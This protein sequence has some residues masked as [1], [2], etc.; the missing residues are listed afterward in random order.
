M[1]ERVPQLPF[2]VEPGHDVFA[3][4][5]VEQLGPVTA[6]LL[7]PVHGG[8]GVAKERLGGAAVGDGDP[9]AGGDDG[10]EPIEVERL[11]GNVQEPFSERVGL[12]DPVELLA[13]DD[14][15]VAA[16]PGHEIAGTQRL[17]EAPTHLDEEPVAGVMAQAVVEDLEPVE[18]EEE[19]RDVGSALASVPT[20][21]PQPFEGLLP[22]GEAGEGVVQGLM[23][24]A[25]LA[26]VAFDGDGGEAPGRVEEALVARLRVGHVWSQDDDRA[27]MLATAARGVD[28][29][30]A[31]PGT[32]S[33]FDQGGGSLSRTRGPDVD[34]GDGIGDPVA[35]GGHR[36]P[37]ERRDA[38]RRDVRRRGDVQDERLGLDDRQHGAPVGDPGVH[39]PG[40][41]VEGRWERRPSGD[42]LEDPGLLRGDELGSTPMRDVAGVDEYP[43]DRRVV[44]E[45]HRHRSRSSAMNRLDAGSDARWVP[46]S[47]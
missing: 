27:E 43:A 7:R 20:D 5:R 10:L 46:G 47:R 9:D 30:L 22:V 23:G 32:E 44:G 41:G 33:V 19:H 21:L 38:G 18:V 6:L 3:E 17:V 31:P 8:V 40:D 24:E 42:G 37:I 28:D 34:A 1:L 29:R 11:A 36:E 12:L 25:R 16:E 26:P 45:Q 2:G 15:L 13:H 14:E 35:V 39:E 4:L